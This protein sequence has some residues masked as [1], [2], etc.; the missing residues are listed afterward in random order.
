MPSIILCALCALPIAAVQSGAP[1]P[2]AAPAREGW[3]ELDRVV[4]IVNEDIVTSHVLFRD[5]EQLRRAR[6]VSNENDAARMRN[7]IMVE[8]VKDKLSVQA[9]RNM[10]LETSLVEAQVD[11]HLKR[12]VERFDGVVGLSEFLQSKD[13]SSTDARDQMRDRLYSDVWEQYVTGESAVPGGRISV[14]KYVRPGQM[15]FMYEVSLERPET[16]ARI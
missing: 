14:D 7:E 15:R 2:A 8:Q 1:Q 11:D 4:V 9:G 5:Y 3:R 13:L 16:L 6:S 10:G 12:T